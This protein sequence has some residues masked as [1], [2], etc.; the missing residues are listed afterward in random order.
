MTEK[1]V[2]TLLRF[3][4]NR[5]LKVTILVTVT[6]NYLNHKST[7]KYVSWKVLSV[8]VYVRTSVW[9][10]VHVCARV[11]TYMQ[12][13]CVVCFGGG[14]RR[15]RHSPPTKHVVACKCLARPRFDLNFTNCWR[16]YER[17]YLLTFNVN[18]AFDVVVVCWDILAITLTMN[19]RSSSSSAAATVRD[20]AKSKKASLVLLASACWVYLVHGLS[21]SSNRCDVIE[22]VFTPNLGLLLLLYILMYSQCIFFQLS[23]SSSS[24]PSFLINQ[25]SH[26][27]IHHQGNGCQFTFLNAITR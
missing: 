21:K 23:L 22:V 5:K 18:T 26:R 4:W 2:C 17:S 19:Q 3:L 6:V 10:R 13:V 8:E 15:C 11:H 25:F 16:K 20:K 1:V 27:Q 9:V 12:I 14:C 24:L 7:L